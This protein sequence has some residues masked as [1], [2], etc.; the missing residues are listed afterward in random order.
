MKHS[1]Q[2]NEL[3]DALAKAQGQF[4][5]AVKDN[6]NPH[7]KSKF[8]S[9]DSC[10][11]ASQKQLSDNGLSILQGVETSPETQMVF[12]TSRLLHKSGQWIEHTT[13]ARPK[14]LA[15]QDVGS[16]TTYLR[17]YGYCSLIS[18]VSDEDNDAEDQTNRGSTPKT[19][20]P[21]EPTLGSS[22]VASSNTTP[23]AAVLFS[24]TNPAHVAAL[25]SF[26]TKFKA[27]KYLPDLIEAMTGRPANAQ[28]VQ[29]AWDT[30]NVNGDVQ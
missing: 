23:G 12:V 13:G 2:I 16:V 7:F 20:G 4:T 27:D 1:E 6:V 5:P 10:R 19:T 29:Q 18:L 30:V 11:D 3:A 17:R 15:P 9:L 22:H 26:L 24:Q 28:S 25:K 14:S 8:A 21:Q